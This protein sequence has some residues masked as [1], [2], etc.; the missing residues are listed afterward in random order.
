MFTQVTRKAFKKLGMALVS[1]TLVLSF[2]AVS[3]PQPVKA[4]TDAVSCD[5][6]YTVKSG[7]T[8]RTIA[9]AYGLKWRDLASA[10]NLNYPYKVKVGQKLCIPASE[11]TETENLKLT[12]TVRGSNVTVKASSSKFRYKYTIKVRAGDTGVGGW[13]KVGSL[14]VPKKSS[15]TVVY[16]LPKD[17][18][19][20]SPI[21]VCLK[22]VTTDNLICRTVIHF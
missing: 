5:T 10:N 7:D 19:T 20:V 22:N 2:L 8:I 18:K 1:L 6:Y 15:V 12:V 3:L 13:Y 11:D 4:A 16:T 9:Q 17:L 21:T 14:T